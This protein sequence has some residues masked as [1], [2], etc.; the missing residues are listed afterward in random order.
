MTHE[1][2]M[3]QPSDLVVHAHLNRSLDLPHVYALTQHMGREGFRE[4]RPIEVG[5]FLDIPGLHLISGHHRVAAAFF[6]RWDELR[7]TVF[8]PSSEGSLRTEYFHDSSEQGWSLPAGLPFAEIPATVVPLA[9]MDELCLKIGDAHRLHDARTNSDL[10][11]PLSDRDLYVLIRRVLKFPDIFRKSNRALSRFYNVSPHVIA[12]ER[13][14][15]VR[16]VD[17]LVRTVDSLV[18]PDD[19]TVECLAEQEFTPERL[20]AV[21]AL[22]E[23]GER[24]VT[25]TRDGKTQEYVQKPAETPA[26]TRD[27]AALRS[28]F[29]EKANLLKRVFE[30]PACN[31]FPDGTRPK[32]VYWQWLELAVNRRPS[33][34]SHW[35]R[36]TQ[37]PEGWEGSPVPEDVAEEMLAIA[38]SLQAEITADVPLPKHEKALADVLAALEADAQEPSVEQASVTLSSS[39]DAPPVPETAMETVKRWAFDPETNQECE[40][41]LPSREA[42]QAALL[43]LD[44][45]T[46]G[47]SSRD[48]ANQ[49][50]EYFSLTDLQRNVQ[51]SAQTRHGV[52]P[53]M[54][55]TEANN[56]VKSG[57]LVKPRRGWFAKPEQIPEGSDSE[58]APSISA[59]AAS[60]NPVEDTLSPTAEESVEA[61]YQQLQG[62]LAADLLLHIKD[63]SPAFFEELVIDLLVAMGY[64]GSREDAEAVG[65]S[66]DGGIDGIINE[67]I[68][69]LDVIYVQAKRWQADVGEPPVRD[70]VG[71]LQGRRARKGIFITTSAFSKGA[72]EY[73]SEVDTKDTKIVLIDG[74]QLAQFMIDHN[75][76]VSVV[77]SYEIKRVDSDYFAEEG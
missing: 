25:R 44:Y 71:A 61:N 11:K 32:G 62:E 70:F 46:R 41:E 28:A 49:L 15:V 9:E 2:R 66:G 52:F 10:A 12:R 69:G 1:I 65:R 17:S 40:I 33:R 60:H 14:T 58:T 57:H 59:A 26:D 5:E 27:Y 31:L 23:S 8:P 63:N 34:W 56:L 30:S 76:G 22:I 20:E 53:H 77:K 51:P 75:V 68:L 48:A 45:P 37:S 73:V 4:D 36:L 29:L 43:E 55:N 6:S 24:T 72:K 67:D 42:I 54:V 74:Y 3:V 50:A 64:G 18:E 38:T 16:T 39:F 21:H 7:G 19:F 35:K 13:R 47:M